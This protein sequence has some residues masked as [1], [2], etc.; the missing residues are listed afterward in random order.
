[1]ANMAEYATLAAWRT[2]PQEDA[3]LAIREGLVPGGEDQ[4][5]GIS[6]HEE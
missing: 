5:R 3:W 2:G 1:M 4:L 6:K